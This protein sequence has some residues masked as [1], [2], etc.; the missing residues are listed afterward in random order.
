M[1]FA[2]PSISLFLNDSYIYFSTI[3]LLGEKHTCPQF[4]I[5]PEMALFTA[6]YKS[7]SFKTTKGSLPPSS[8]TDFLRY[9][10][11]LAA[12]FDPALVLPVKLTPITDLCE[13]TWSRTSYEA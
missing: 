4:K 12:I 6:N 7:A 2:N 13:K 11:A 9:Y 3:N 1:T 10:P 5:L 8:I